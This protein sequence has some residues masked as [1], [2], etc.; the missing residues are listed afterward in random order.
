M[1]W[2][3]PRPGSEGSVTSLSIVAVSEV[4]AGHHRSRIPVT[5]AVVRAQNV[6]SWMLWA[7]A[8]AAVNV[9]SIQDALSGATTDDVS[10][11]V[12]LAGAANPAKPG[13]SPSATET[14]WVAAGPSPR[15]RL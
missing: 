6:A 2:V 5:R 15:S 7:D 10:A 1:M 11:R 4:G 13:A 8:S 9:C 3:A 12:R 14:S